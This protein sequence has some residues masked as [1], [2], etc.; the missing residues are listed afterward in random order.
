MSTHSTRLCSCVASALSI[1]YKNELNIAGCLL[2]SQLAM[3]VAL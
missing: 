2:V 1:E 3:E